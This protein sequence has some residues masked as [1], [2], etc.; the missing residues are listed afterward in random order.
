MTKIGKTCYNIGKNVTT[1]HL[2]NFSGE[3]PSY[4]WS[5]TQEPLEQTTPN[6]AQVLMLT[7]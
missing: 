7:D 2:V 5:G 1:F 3:S 6:F 4:F